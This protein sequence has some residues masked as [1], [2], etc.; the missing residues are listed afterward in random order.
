MPVRRRAQRVPSPDRLT[1]FAAQFDLLDDP[2]VQRLV[3]TAALTD[4]PTLTRVVGQVLSLKAL[5][6]HQRPFPTPIPSDTAST[7][8]ELGTAI[9]GSRFTLAPADLAQHLLVVGQS[10]AGKTTLLYN[11]M[12]QLPVPFWS[13]DLKQDYRHLLSNDLDLLV[14]PWTELK[15]NPLQ[16]PPGVPPRRWAQVFSEVFGHAT[17]LLSGSKNYL[18]QQVIELYQLYDLFDEVSPPFP[19]FHELQRLMEADKLNYVRKT[20][21][22]RDTVVNRLA[23]MN[24]TAGTIFDCSTGYPLEELLEQNVVFEFDGLATDVQNLLMELL[25][26]AVYEY[27]LAQNQRNTGL[28]HVFVL[29]EGKRIFSVYK[30]RQAAAGL[31]TIDEMTAKMRE[32]GEGLVVADQE[33]TKLTESIKANTYTTVLLATGDATQF[34]K[35]ADT[36]RLTNRQQDLAY[37]LGTGEAIIQT[38][39]REP[40]PVQLNNVDVAKTISDATLRKQ[41][42][43]EWNDLSAKPREYPAAFLKQVGES[44]ADDTPE[45]SPPSAPPVEESLSGAADRLLA[46]VVARPFTPLTDRY[47]R[48]N[49]AYQGNRAKNELVDQ[50]LVIE[51]QVRA[52]PE[53]RK[54]LELTDQGREYA[55]TRLDLESGQRGRGGIVH[56]YWQYRLCQRFADAGWPAKR[57]LFDADVYVNLGDTELVIEVAMTNAAREAAHVEQHLA[58]GFDAVWVVCRTEA[59]R[60]G[61]RERLAENGL[62]TDQV[63]L[64]LVRDVCDDE[65]SPFT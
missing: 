25:L 12:Q 45:N 50:G 30:E 20:A 9:T 21:N 7:A 48:F 2:E 39:N 4:D 10:G 35:V 46:D 59:V 65:F 52:G 14:L 55:E 36:M 60:A 40:C 31:P 11:L 56:Q 29:D 42:R 17:A 53:K 5:H 24:L 15:L 34:Q 18:M 22:Y 37:R 8:L 57:E 6:H 13:F 58:T 61:I 23:A 28:H 44:D 3:T 47:E 41:Q 1:R 51:R 63:S 19:S 32:F 43:P 38:G 64:R 62:L 26:A 49:S 16:P 27:R 33:A 54:L